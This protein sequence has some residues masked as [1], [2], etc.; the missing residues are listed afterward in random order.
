M[1][2]TFQTPPLPDP[3]VLMLMSRVAALEAEIRRLEDLIAVDPLPRAGVADDYKP[4]TIY[5]RTA[6]GGL[7]THGPFYA[8][9]GRWVVVDVST[10]SVTQQPNG[11][12]RPDDDDIPQNE[13][14]I[15][16]ENEAEYIT[17]LG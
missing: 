12:V 8:A 7:E 6:I 2:S 11:T 10:E 1:P 14:W 5:L 15:D 3:V 9:S 16:L 17:R 13:V 4:R